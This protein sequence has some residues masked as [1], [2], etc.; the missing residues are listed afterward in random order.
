MQWAWF[1]SIE[2][3]SVEHIAR[4]VCSML[5]CGRQ[6]EEEMASI[7]HKKSLQTMIEKMFPIK[8]WSSNCNE[9]RT[10]KQNTVFKIFHWEFFPNAYIIMQFK[11]LK[12]GIP[13]LFNI[14]VLVI[15]YFF[16]CSIFLRVI[17]DISSFYILQVQYDT[18]NQST[19]TLSSPDEQSLYNVKS[20]P[21]GHELTYSIP[22][23]MCHFTVSWFLTSKKSVSL[24]K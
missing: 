9:T 15:D 24:S 20:K 6:Y 23:S 13:E 1:C 22:N 16:S 14:N 12:T 10:H 2:L 7:D 19:F 8:N 18:L 11:K 5:L 17:L 3:K 4:S 21:L